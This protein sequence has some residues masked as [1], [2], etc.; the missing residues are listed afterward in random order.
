MTT[1]TNNRHSLLGRVLDGRGQPL[2]DGPE[3]TENQRAMLELVAPAAL[4]APAAMYETGIKAIDF[5]AP[6]L[7][8]GTTVMSGGWGV[9]KVVTT[10]E[11]INTLATRHGGAA[12][13]GSLERDQVDLQTKL[14]WLREG[15]TDAHTTVVFGKAGEGA[16]VAQTAL[17]LAEH[18]C[19]AGQDV[20]LVLDDA[21]ICDATLP[22]LLGR[23]RFSRGHALT[24]LL[25]HGVDEPAGA[26]LASYV[27]QADGLISFS[28]EL[29]QQRIW[30]AIDGT[31]CDSRLF[32][33]GQARAE[34]RQ[35][36]AAA[37]ALLRAGQGTTADAATGERVRRVLF[38]QSQPFTVAEPFTGKPGVALPL[39]ETLRGF[40]A[41][42]NDARPDLPTERIYFGGALPGN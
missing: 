4:S 30:P 3:L 36:R 11:L 9:G 5:Y 39:A 23:L 14:G 35:L 19:V 2:D 15:G 21:V 13:I 29:A 7:R 38:F 24:V 28:A 12:V 37:L 41:L 16:M 10:N 18:M 20:F 22:R 6:L 26:A 1:I 31:Q 17:A 25:W 8:G 32:A 40:Q 34:H 42:L 33:E 27:Q